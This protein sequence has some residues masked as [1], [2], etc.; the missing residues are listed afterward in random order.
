MMGRII[1]ASTITT[2]SV[3]EP[4]FLGVLIASFAVTWWIVQPSRPAGD[5]N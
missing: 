2:A 3:L 1:V 5:L 4:T